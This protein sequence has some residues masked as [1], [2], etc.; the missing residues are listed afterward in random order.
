MTGEVTTQRHQEQEPE[1]G[2]FDRVCEAVTTCLCPIPDDPEQLKNTYHEKDI[3]DYTFEKV[4]TFTCGNDED[5]VLEEDNMSITQGPPPAVAAKEQPPPAQVYADRATDSQADGQPKGVQTSNEEGDMLDYVFE[6]VESLVCAE[7][8]PNDKARLA[9]G[10][11]SVSRDHSLIEAPMEEAIKE[12]VP[13]KEKPVEEDEESTYIVE[14]VAPEP[15]KQPKKKGLFFKRLVR[16]PK[17]KKRTD[18]SV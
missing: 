18:A 2:G 14:F 15:E 1:E 5:T 4:E 6:K 16:T 9:A 12:D 10:A 11:A 17:K 13:P 7:D 3:L 8:V